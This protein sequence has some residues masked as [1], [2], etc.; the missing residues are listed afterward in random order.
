[1]VAATMNQNQQRKHAGDVKKKRPVQK[2][3]AV[4]YTHLDVYKRQPQDNVVR[5]HKSMPMEI[6]TIFDP[7]GNAVHTALSWDMVGEDVLITGAGVIGYV[8]KRQHRDHSGNLP[9]LVKQGFQGNIYS[10]FATRDLCQLML[11][12]AARIQ[13]QDVYKRQDC[14]RLCLQ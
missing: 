2:C 13:E 10:T 6:A 4:S 8:Y 14:Y 11:A 1:M 7:L 12:D 9:N 5:I 3:S